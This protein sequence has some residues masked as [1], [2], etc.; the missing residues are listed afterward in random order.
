LVQV[1]FCWHRA[2]ENYAVFYVC[3][4]GGGGGPRERV[5]SWTIVLRWRD[6]CL[7][8]EFI[9]MSVMIRKEIDGAPGEEEAGPFRFCEKHH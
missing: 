9:G 4:Y 6:R 2:L 1:Y 8:G 3:L 5:G 7:E